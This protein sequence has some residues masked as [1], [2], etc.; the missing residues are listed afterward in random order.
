M[1]WFVDRGRTRILFPKRNYDE[2]LKTLRMFIGK[3]GDIAE[4]LDDAIFL[5]R[6]MDPYGHGTDIYDS[7]I[8]ESLTLFFDFL[9]SAHVKDPWR[10]LF[11]DCSWSRPSEQSRNFLRSAIR[12][13][14]GP[15][16]HTEIHITTKS[17]HKDSI[18]D[19]F[20]VPILKD[21]MYAMCKA[22]KEVSKE[23]YQV[24]EEVSEE[25]N[26]GVNRDGIKPLPLWCLVSTLIE[27]GADIHYMDSEKFDGPSSWVSI[28][29]PSLWAFKYD[30]KPEWEAALRECGLDPTEVLR[31][32]VQRCKQA[33]RLHGAKRTGVDEEMLALPSAAGLRCRICRR[34]YCGKHGTRTYL[35]GY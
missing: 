28:R 24:S 16:R 18:H 12:L 26:L 29:T 32:D 35:N 6:N 2:M 15:N 11:F 25:N 8:V 27:A 23:A 14:L 19:T 34:K 3:G 5:I 22:K 10:W 30:V 31:E 4:A 17:I 20:G 1:L 13:G 33:F 21:A 7:D 9:A